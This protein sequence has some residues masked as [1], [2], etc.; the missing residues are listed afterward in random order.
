MGGGGVPRSREKELAPEE[1]CGLGDLGGGGWAWH[2]HPSPRLWGPPL[3]TT[4]RTVHSSSTPL[5]ASSL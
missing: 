2:R 1:G 4:P 3:Q 5:T